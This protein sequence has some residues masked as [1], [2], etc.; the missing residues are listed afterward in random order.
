MLNIQNLNKLDNHIDYVSQKLWNKDVFL[1]GWCVRD[2]L[3]GITTSPL[4]LDVTL[5]GQPK[6]IANK[7]DKSEI[8]FFMTEKYGTMTII[9]KG[10][11]EVEKWQYEITP[12]R[13]ESQYTDERH[14]DEVH[15]TDNLVQDA[16]RRDFTINAM[17]YTRIG[18][19]TKDL[20]TVYDET[21]IHKHL[22]KEWIFLAEKAGLVIICEHWLIESFFPAGKYDE[23]VFKQY[24]EKNYADF[25]YVEFV[26]SWV[27][28]LI[29][30]YNWI[31][32]MIER[33]IKAV[34]DPDKRIAEDALRILR[35]LRFANVLNDKIATIWSEDWNSIIRKSFFDIEKTTRKAVKKNYYR[36]QHVAKER[37]KIELDK[38]FRS[39]NPFGLI[40]LLD[41]TNL[42]KTLF[43]AVFASKWVNQPVR[44]HPFDVY[45]HSM[46]A[47]SEL[48]KINNNYLVKYA[49]LYH[50]VGK[51]EQYYSYQM[52]LDQDEI[53]AIFGTWLNHVNCGVDM[54]K[55]DFDA[56]GFS[57]KEVDEISW[58]VQNHMKPGEVL[59]AWRDNW[60]KKLRKLLSD[61][62]PERL[63]NLLDIT[64]GDRLWQFNPMQPAQVEDIYELK[65]MLQKLLDQEWQFTMKSLAV[66][67][68]DIMAEMGIEPW[69]KLWEL[70]TKAFDWVIDDIENRNNKE[71]ILAYINK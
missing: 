24:F 31:I 16:Q 7:I 17:Y 44:Y 19:G 55:K 21:I 26:S 34:G 33:K 30:P 59:M 18:I 29:D 51:T 20:T 40:W 15:W 58:Y 3:L 57:R 14:P 62:W 52:W 71:A 49:M 38:A 32:D 9:P 4:D 11:E 8:S 54:V 64:I 5:A 63:N 23:Q 42:L 60:E 22:L 27:A 56:L 12:F 6:S 50:D 36:L 28:F 37:L 66:T 25:D 68:N 35:A 41:E 69:P 61:G 67:G 2:I 53:R 1:V 13:T 39:N 10:Q 70:L 46:L 48:Q 65:I 47:L 45:V 43:P